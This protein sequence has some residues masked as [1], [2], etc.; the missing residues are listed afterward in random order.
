M[1]TNRTNLQRALR[2]FDFRKL[3]LEELGW[4]NYAAP[5]PVQVDGATYTL[6]GIAEKRG[7]A[8]FVL[9]STGGLPDH[10]LRRKIERQVAKAHRE[11]LI[12][13]SDG[14]PTQGG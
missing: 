10:S 3:F 6:Q 11:H 14:R 8:A 9:T 2:A 5:L 1:K 7:V 12:I 4:D 13:F